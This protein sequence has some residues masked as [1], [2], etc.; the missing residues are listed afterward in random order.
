MLAPVFTPKTPTRF[1]NLCI[2]TLMAM[3]LKRIQMMKAVM[4]KKLTGQQPKSFV[5]V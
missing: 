4:R 5:S 3:Q 1:L 2:L